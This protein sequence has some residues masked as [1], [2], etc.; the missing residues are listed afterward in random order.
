MNSNSIVWNEQKIEQPIARLYCTPASSAIP[1]CFVSVS[2]RKVDVLF[3]TLRNRGR[4]I[5]RFAWAPTILSL[6][7]LL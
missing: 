5:L 7:A 3:Q 4:S 1:V 6:G 2:F